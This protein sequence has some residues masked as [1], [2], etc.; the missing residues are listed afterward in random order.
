M[1]G[2]PPGTPE[3]RPALSKNPR[4]LAGTERNGT[5]RPSTQP[6]GEISV[7]RLLDRDQRASTRQRAWRLRGTPNDYRHLSSNHNAF[8]AARHHCRAS[9][10]RLT[11]VEIHACSSSSVFSWCTTV[12]YGAHTVTV[13]APRFETPS[14]LAAGGRQCGRC[15]AGR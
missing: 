13:T 5:S 6:A 4:R 1:Q 14:A 7:L 15:L 10:A 11:R 2:G 3:Y 9:Q 8:P 12:G